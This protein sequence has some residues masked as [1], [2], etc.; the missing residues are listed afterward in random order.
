MSH[1]LGHNPPERC[2]A[3]LT[4]WRAGGMRD[5]CCSANQP[6]EY[7]ARQLSRARRCS[8]ADDSSSEICF[9]FWSSAWSGG[10]ARRQAGTVTVKPGSGRI[11]GGARLGAVR[12]RR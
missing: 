4:E 8:S 3:V 6:L 12:A 7:T 5:R 10:M 1:T 11:D 2:E 9:I